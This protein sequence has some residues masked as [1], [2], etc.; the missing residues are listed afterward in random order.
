MDLTIQQLDE[1][2]LA[3]SCLALGALIDFG[4]AHARRSGFHLLALLLELALD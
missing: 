3:G 2:R 1:S 4:L